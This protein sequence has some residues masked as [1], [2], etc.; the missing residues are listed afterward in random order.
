[1]ETYIT[2]IIGHCLV[3]IKI[4]D[5]QERASETR[6]SS[7]FVNKLKHRSFLNRHDSPMCQYQINNNN[8]IVRICK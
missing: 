5:N 2:V 6:L 4:G 8:N 3:Y 1:M 7:F